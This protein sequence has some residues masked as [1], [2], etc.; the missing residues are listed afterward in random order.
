MQAVAVWDTAGA[1]GVPHFMAFAKL[2]LDAVKD[3]R[4]RN[5]DLDINTKHAFQAL[6]L[7]ERRAPFAPAIWERKN[8]PALIDLR[9]VWFPGTHKNVGGVCDDK[10]LA[11]ITLAW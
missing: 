2:G 11:N 5:T 3:Y 9:Q 6:A 7:D 1:L 10:E 8:D 4:F